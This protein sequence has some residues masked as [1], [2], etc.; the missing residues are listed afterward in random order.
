VPKGYVTPKCVENLNTLYC[1][2]SIHFLKLI[3]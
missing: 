3:P 2:N 1:M